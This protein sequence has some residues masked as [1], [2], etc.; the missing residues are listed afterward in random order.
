MAT[1][2]GFGSRDWLAAMLAAFLLW[3]GV[4]PYDRLTWVLEVF[5]VAG[6]VVLWFAWLRR[7]RVT[8]TLFALVLVH[9]VVL[10]EGGIHTYERE[11]LGEIVQEWTGRTRNDYDRFGHFMQGLAPA[12]LWREVF[13]R[14]AVIRAR[15]WLAPIVVGMCLAFAAAFELLEFGVAM[16]LG[17]ASWAYLG[18]QG[19]VWDAQWD[20]LLCV[21]GAAVALLALAPLQDV[22]LRRE[23]E[24]RR[25][26]PRGD[27]PLTR[28]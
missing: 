3:S 22:E 14:N 9:S 12:I 15:G 7:H 16:A 8:W 2:R 25:E 21:V 6:A 24:P 13:V 27:G 1:P 11:P 23:E 18:S 19:D 28:P 20:M 17:E 26:E 10:I 5:W 4:A